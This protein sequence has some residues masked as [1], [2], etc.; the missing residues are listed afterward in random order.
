MS[1]LDP[2]AFDTALTRVVEAT[3]DGVEAV[4]GVVARYSRGD[5]QSLLTAGQGEFITDLNAAMMTPDRGLTLGT[6]SAVFMRRFGTLAE[7][8]ARLSERP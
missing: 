2:E 3:A 6:S 4:L 8:K 1:T 5:A 7:A